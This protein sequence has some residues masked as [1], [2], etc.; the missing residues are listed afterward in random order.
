MKTIILIL[1]SLSTLAK[2]DFLSPSQADRV[3]NYMY[4]ICMDTYCGGDF[5]FIND[6]LSCSGSTCEIKMYGQ[7]FSKDD[8]T[9]GSDLYELV[10]KEKKL[11]N[12]IIKF[13]DV[14]TDSDEDGK[15]LSAGFTCVMPNLPMTD[16]SYDEKEE[17]MYDLI[18]W[19]CVRAFEDAAY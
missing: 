19:D 18:V 12:A 6:K 13:H 3:T 4:N 9:F 1:L 8:V 14:E 17:L 7:A 11:E 10:G 16:M 2:T 15:Y 5:Y